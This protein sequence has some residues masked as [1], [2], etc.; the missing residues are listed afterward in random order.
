[1]RGAVDAFLSQMR[2]ELDKKAM[3]QPP[4]DPAPEPAKPVQP[5]SPQPQPKTTT[6]SVP[7]EPWYRDG[8]GWGLA[9]AGVAGVAVS[10]ILFVNAKGIEDDANDQPFQTD[11]D[12]LRDRASSRRTIATIVG[13]GGAGALV[14]G[15]V[16]LAL[17]PS[18]RD[19]TAATSLNVGVTADTVFVMGRF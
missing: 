6:I 12:A 15:L 11:R 10:T 17:R 13:I 1:M 19:E 8:I 18:D 7:G 9:G 2:S 5:V 3:R 16:K 4:V 14:A